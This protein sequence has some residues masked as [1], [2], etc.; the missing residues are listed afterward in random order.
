MSDAD[1]R[2][3]SDEDVRTALFRPSGALS[4]LQFRLMGFG[5][6]LALLV[7]LAPTWLMTQFGSRRE[8]SLYSGVSLLGLTPDG[9]SPMD[10]AGTVLFLSYL[11]LA[12]G[13][14]LVPPHTGAPVL[15]GVAGLV[16]TVVIIA[17]Q[18]DGSFQMSVS[19]TGAPAVAVG[20]WIIATVVS[21]VALKK[22]RS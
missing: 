14:L 8:T 15:M 18:P 22:T 21:I 19:W 9:N 1:S 20:L 3:T 2:D 11:V 7:T 12:L 16:V 4:R 17:N 13:F 6:G 5:M 10:A